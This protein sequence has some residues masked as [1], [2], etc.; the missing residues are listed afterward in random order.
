MMKNSKERGIISAWSI[1]LR[2]V[3]IWSVSVFMTFSV[4]C[5]QKTFGQFP[6]FPPD[7]VTRAMD[8]D[9]M[10]WQLGI[11]FLDLPSKFKDPHAPKN[12]WP[13][14]TSRPE[15]NWTDSM[16][17]TFTRSGFGLWNNYDDNKT[18]LYTPIDLS[19][20]KDGTVI[21][22]PEQ[23][24]NLRRPEIYKD[25]TE[26]VWGVIPPDSI[27]PRVTFSRV[28]S[29]GEGAGSV[30]IQKVI[31]GII[32]SSRYPHVRNVP[33]IKATLRIPAGKKKAV[34]VMVVFGMGRWTP[35]DRYWEICSGHG[36]GV[37]IF[38]CAALQPDN[39]QFLTSYIIGLCNKGNWRKP[40]DWGSLA[41]WSWG[42]SKLIDYFETD[43]DVPGP[44]GD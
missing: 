3:Y 4:L 8:R 14:D 10:M 20:I 16:H 36:W 2:S 7:T 35:V 18:G 9:Q 19:K 37:C 33:R 11:S 1:P 6:D 21:T 5:I 43:P 28:I 34:P 24:W 23:W 39:G 27:L 41:A 30:Y 40:T 29:T 44:G 13:D 17:H 38:D 25:I 42:V 22:T 15:G 26:Q 31:T 32:D 12:A